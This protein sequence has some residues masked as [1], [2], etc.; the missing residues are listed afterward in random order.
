MTRWRPRRAWFAEHAPR[1]FAIATKTE[2]LDPL[3]A[4][5]QKN[6]ASG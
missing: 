4:V 5:W 6:F 1:L 3:A 2:A